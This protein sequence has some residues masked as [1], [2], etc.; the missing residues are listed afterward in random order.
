LFVTA[1]TGDD[2]NTGEQA[3]GS[4]ALFL[5]K[6]QVPSFDSISVHISAEDMK[7]MHVSANSIN[8]NIKIDG[9]PLG[10]SRNFEVKIYADR[11][12][13][14]QQGKATA[15]INANQVTTIPISLTAISGFLK[16]EIPLGL[17]N[18]A[19]V[20]SGKLFL[21]SQEYQMQIENGKGIFNTGALPLNETFTLRLEL[22]NLAGDIIFTGEKSITLSSILR[23]ETMPL[24]PAG[25]S[26]I[27][28]LV[29]SLD[30][31]VQILAFLPMSI[32]REP[33]NYGDL[34]FTEIFADPK[35][36]GGEY[37][38][39]LEIYNATL[40][41]LELS[42]CRVALSKGTVTVGQN[43]MNLPENLYLPPMEYLIF[44]RDS[45]T[46]M[47]F[48]YER[49]RLTKSGTSFGFFCGD[50]V[51][52]TL[53][54]NAKGDNPFPLALGKAMQLPLENHA[55]RASGT[56]WCFGFSPKEDAFCQ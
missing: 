45:V 44:G 50:F 47:D 7:D 33:Q 26:V 36:T 18:T 8:D 42:H 29:A 30:K 46:N 51:I 2:G 6:L 20:H 49:F 22:R 37:F 11:G 12:K 39:Y 17:A 28:E 24:Q 5:G 14:V 34:F 25:G 1:C 32:T 21:N 52:D 27:L 41:T 9:I 15:N 43:R 3:D 55:N 40:D 31:P 54:F 4:V 53:T 16:L 38:Q 19:D 13:L 23:T 10:E 48:N 56:S 35:S